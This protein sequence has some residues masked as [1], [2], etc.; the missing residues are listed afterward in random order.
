[1]FSRGV[2]FG[3]AMLDGASLA[4][5]RAGVSC[6]ALSAQAVLDGALASLL[7]LLSPPLGRAS[8]FV[9]GLFE[10][11]TLLAEAR[12][13]PLDALDEVVQLAERVARFRD[14]VSSF[15]R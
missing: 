2:V 8:R 12:H 9:E 6:G 7:R 3:R 1:L 10:P 13:V 14:V 15:G 11:P 4:L 5:E